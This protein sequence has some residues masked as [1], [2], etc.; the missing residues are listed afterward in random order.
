M[1]HRKEVHP[2]FKICRKYESGA[3]I[4]GDNC[5][6]S[7]SE[8]DTPEINAN[9]FTCNLCNE[10]FEGRSTFMIHKKQVHTKFVPECEKNSIGKCPRG[11]LECWFVH[12]DVEKVMSSESVF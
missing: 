5:W 6:Y 9:R 7:H 10:V 12:K 4:H 1:H 11:P 2:S 8:L 3:C